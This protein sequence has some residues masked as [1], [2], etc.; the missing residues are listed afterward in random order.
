MLSQLINKLEWR[1][2]R[3]A[4]K[5]EASLSEIARQTKTTKANTFRV[6]NKLE[7]LDLARKRII[8]KAHLYKLN[9]LHNEAKQILNLLCEEEK[10]FYNKKL[11]N[12]PLSI[13]YFLQNLLKDNYQGIIFFGSSL[14]NKYNDIDAF[15]MLKNK[16]NIEEIEKKLKQINNKLSPLFGSKEELEKGLIEKDMFY[17]NVIEGI[18]FGLNILEIKNKEEFLKKEDIK[19]RFILGYREILSCLEIKDKEYQ[20]IHFEKGIIDIVY[21]LLNYHGYSPKN[22]AEATSLFKNKFKISKPKT[23]KEAFNIINQYMPL[24]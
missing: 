17:K 22:D 12:I 21:A 2:L 14:E 11:N 1:I 3:F 15:I 4:I 7:S 6:L 16:K 20:K 13:H 19:E 8:G 10:E 24:L 23:M 5:N 18:S 9:F